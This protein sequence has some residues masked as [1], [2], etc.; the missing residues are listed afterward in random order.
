[1]D[2]VAV[3][4]GG[5]ADRSTGLGLAIVR[6]FCDA[7]GVRVEFRE[8]AGGGLTVRLTIPQAVTT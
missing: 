4:A 5:P 1:V 3:A 7:M 2:P 6:G 8:T